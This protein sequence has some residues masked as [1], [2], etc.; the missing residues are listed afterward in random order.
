MAKLFLQLILIVASFFGLWLAI[1]QVDW[2]TMF[3]VEKATQNV[4]EKLGELYWDIFKNM[5]DEVTDTKVISAVDSLLTRIC[6]R[7]DI[8][9]EKIKLHLINKDEVNAFALPDDHLVI[10][11]GLIADCENESEL[12]GVIAHELAH[13][14][15]GHIMKK[16]VK[17][18]G[19]SVLLSMTTG[20]GN[21]EIIQQAIKVL[22]SSAYDRNL[23]READLSGA[24]YLINAGIDPEGFAQFMF[25]MSTQEQDVPEQLFWISTHPGSEQ[26]TKDILDYIDG[27]EVKVEMVLDSTQWLTLKENLTAE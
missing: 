11:S 15:K 24:D 20:N 13:L 5:E 27:R 19:L 1:G 4:E 2:M 6:D 7:N 23:E 26:R 8:D 21:P 10:F 25:R 9:R 3:K 16:L 18:V 12:C 17:E 22:T 14:E